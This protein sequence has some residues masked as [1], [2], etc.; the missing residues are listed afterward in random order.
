MQSSCLLHP[1]ILLKQIGKCRLTLQQLQKRSSASCDI[2]RDSDIV[3]HYVWIIKTGAVALHY[4]Q[5]RIFPQCINRPFLLYLSKEPAVY[6]NDENVRLL[7]NCCAYKN[8]QLFSPKIVDMQSRWIMKHAEHL[9]VH[10]TVRC[11]HC[12]T[13][14]T[15]AMQRNGQARS[16]YL[17][18][19][20]EQTRCF[21]F[22]FFLKEKKNK[23]EFVCFSM[24]KKPCSLW[25]SKVF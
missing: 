15:P 3:I 10:R 12:A 7:V 16:K 22:F 20:G 2:T 24:T 4:L 5:D 23:R 25:T 14:A 17:W 21:F 1:N 18:R 13:C 11:R 6:V 8:I 19:S 9:R